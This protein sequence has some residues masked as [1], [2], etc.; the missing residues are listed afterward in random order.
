MKKLHIVKMKKWIRVKWLTLSDENGTPMGESYLNY[1]DFLWAMTKHYKTHFHWRWG[2]DWGW[3]AHGHM[4]VSVPLDEYERFLLK[5]KTFNKSK[6]RPFKQTHY[7]DFIEGFSTEEYACEKHTRMRD[8]V[9]CPKKRKPCKR[10]E[11]THNIV[12]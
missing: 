3:D 9:R 8:K 12:G 6:H 1:D 2:A 11:C 4:I 7:I 5:D 10:G